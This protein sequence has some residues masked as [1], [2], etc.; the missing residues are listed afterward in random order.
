MDSEPQISVIIPVLYGDDCWKT[1]L[2]DLTSFPDSSEFL[3]VSNSEQPAEFS[4]LIHQF[5]LEERSHWY[6]T[7]VGRAHQMNYGAA[8]A[9]RSHLL[10]LHA[11]SGLSETGIQR[12]IQSL[13]SHPNALH[14]FNL[15][16]QD[17]SF[18]LM[19]LNTWGVYFR[20]HV[21]GIPFGDQGLCL[22]CALFHELG[23]FDESAPY[24]EDHL[25]V[26]KAR[27]GRIR[28]Q[29][30]GAEIQT[31]ARKYQQQG[32]F[33][34]TVKHLWLTIRQ[35]VPQFILLLK[36]RIGSW[37]QGKAPSSSS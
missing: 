33:K 8:Q 2:A 10:F 17:Q 25:L 32:W 4:E 3:F 12:L 19:Q 31:S 6:Q 15:K 34:M 26:W 18:F 29:C 14:Y 11:D 35:A 1:L 20:S 21:L 24:G 23:C 36:E 7:L 30:T 22:S 13:K 37:F 27:R 16:F 28:L 5:Q 9:S